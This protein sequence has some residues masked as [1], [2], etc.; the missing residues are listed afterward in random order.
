M[1]LYPES[2][3]RRAMKVVEVILKAMAREIKWIQAADILGVTPR[4]IRR[5][6]L[7]YQAQGIGGLYDRRRGQPSKR[8]APY[9]LVEKVLCLYADKYFDFNVKHFHE[10]LVSRHGL[11]CSYTWTK[12]LLQT[13][14]YVK[15]DKGRG[16]HRKRRERRPLFGQMLHLDGSE[17]EWLALKPGERQVLLLVVDDATGRN[18]AAKLVEAETTKTCMGVMRGV[19]ENYGIPAQLYTDRHSVYWYTQKAGGKVDRERLTQFGRA[20]EEL[21][22][23]M[24]PGYSPQARGRSERWNGTWQGR[25]VA[26]L[27][28]AG[29][30]DL[31]AANRYI[32]TKFL[33]AVNQQ[34]AKAPVEPGS[35]F[36]G[37]YGAD[38]D[39]I[40]AIRYD[41]RVV[42]NDN[43][44]RVNHLILQLEKSRFRDHFVKCRVE[45]FEHLDGTYAVFWKK[46][47]IGRYD[48]QGQALMINPGVQPPDPR[49]LPLGGPGKTPKKGK[50]SASPSSPDVPPALGL[51]SSVALSSGET[52][53][54]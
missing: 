45:V 14:G 9:E 20:L 49:S 17:H 15:R 16:G 2:A 43:T 4:H 24:I 44:V 39:R 13:A 12:N 53:P 52:S 7:A 54:G 37:A 50:R 27:R 41:G 46:R 28:L 1:K 8:R 29:I 48:A 33:P 34:F 22:V 23:E 36:V 25:L 3:V 21:G 18:L 42:A 35:A 38:L 5:L 31:A 26:E 11:S 30:A 32:T 19:V 6:R 10:Q 47:V 40:F 51:L